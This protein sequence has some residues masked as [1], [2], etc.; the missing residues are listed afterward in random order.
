MAG[1]HELA[2][3]LHR[4][5]APVGSEASV[6]EASL[7]SAPRRCWASLRSSVDWK[8]MSPGFSLPQS[9]GS[10]LRSLRSMEFNHGQGLWR[11]SGGRKRREG[12]DKE[13]KRNGVGQ[14]QTTSNQLNRIPKCTVEMLAWGLHLLPFLLVKHM[15][16]T[17][18]RPPC[19][20]LLY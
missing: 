2:Y 5:A 9:W 6:V 11:G 19:H 20:S 4:G 16:F 13:R 8:K 7:L 18:N 10:L 14:L 1:D 12:S 3:L 15:L 17:D